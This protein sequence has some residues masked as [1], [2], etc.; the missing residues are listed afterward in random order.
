ML[1]NLRRLSFILNNEFDY[2]NA[3][4]L[5]AWIP[6]N[7]IL[8]SGQIA[9]RLEVLNFAITRSQSV[10]TGKVYSDDVVG[11]GDIWTDL[12]DRV[13]FPKLKRVA[14]YLEIGGCNPSV[15]NADNFLSVISQK[16]P[17]LAEQGLLHATLCE[18]FDWHNVL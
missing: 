8:H 16:L 5:T 17:L 9:L 4:P 11:L 13:R 15:L 14:I 10:R 12:A 3:S 2:L 1:Q 7:N 18:K 6:I